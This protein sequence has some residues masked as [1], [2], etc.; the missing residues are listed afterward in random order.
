[1]SMILVRVSVPLLLDN[2]LLFSLRSVNL[3]SDADN[4]TSARQIRL[5]RQGIYCEII[6]IVGCI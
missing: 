6:Y 5:S 3:P 2:P 1:M 4:S